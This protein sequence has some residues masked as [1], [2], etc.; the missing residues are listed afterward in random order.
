MQRRKFL[1]STLTAGSLVALNKWE[2]F[3]GSKER[4]FSI[5]HTNDVHSRLEP[6]PMDGGQYQGMGGITARKQAI[7]KIKTENATTFLFDCGDIF[8]G[9]PYFNKFKGEP[10]MKAMQ[11]LGYE[12]GTMGN[13]DFDGGVE[14][15]ANQLIH[16]NF[17]IIVCNY[18][19]ANT[20]LEDKIPP[21]TIIRKNGIKLGIIGVGIALEGLVPENLYKG[22]TY[23]NPIPLVNYWANYLRTIKKCDMVVVLSHLGFDYKDNKLSDKV[24]AKE[25]ENVNVILGG[26]THTFLD[27]PF[28]AQ[29]KLQKTVLI[30]QAGWG[31]IQLGH[32]QFDLIQENNID[33][34]INVSS[35]I[36]LK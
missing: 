16:I 24:L 9:T 1:K 12:A 27:E 11:M 21:Y 23:Q 8:Q 15:F 5:L 32:L 29:N 4:K 2:V 28:F 20:P 19:F 25:T 17:P 34:K 26:H 14:N 18:N 6:F 33:N 13:H 30:N 22:V 36:Y 35:G 31:G 3:A 7:A 10:E